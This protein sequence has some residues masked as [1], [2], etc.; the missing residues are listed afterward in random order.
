MAEPEAPEGRMA[1]AELVEPVA[2]EPQAQTGVLV[3]MAK[4]AASGGMAGPVVAADRFQAMAARVVMPVK[5][6]R[7]ERAATVL[8]VPTV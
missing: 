2:T 3:K 4:R 8:P 7:V 1:M 5:E 6:A